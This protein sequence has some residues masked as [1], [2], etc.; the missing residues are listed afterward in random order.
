MK[1]AYYKF[2]DKGNCTTSTSVFALLDKSFIE[3]E[4][5][6]KRTQ[7]DQNHLLERKRQ[8]L[9]KKFSNGLKT[10][11]LKFE[12]IYLNNPYQQ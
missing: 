4:Y 5:T 9:L 2:S 10:A 8:T 7:G 1:L 11:A 12:M 6:I 3:F